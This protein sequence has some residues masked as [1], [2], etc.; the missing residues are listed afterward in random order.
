MAW[1]K[2]NMDLFEA[3]VQ[4]IAHGVNCQGVM[5]SGVAKEIR[6]RFPA[7]FDVYR[8]S[9]EEGTLTLGSVSIVSGTHPWVLNIA[10]QVYYGREPGRVYADPVAIQRGLQT[11]LDV[12]SVAG[13]TTLGIPAIGAGLGG[14]PLKALE[15]ALDALTYPTGFKILL[16]IPT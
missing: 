1:E 8:R 4:A 5:A 16:C 6:A 2:I 9:Y 15:D 7:A 12:L 3:P 14:L 13:V 11:A 10:T